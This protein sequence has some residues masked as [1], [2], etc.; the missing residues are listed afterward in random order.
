[1]TTKDTKV[2]LAVKTLAVGIQKAQKEMIEKLGSLV[3]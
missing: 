3:K 2:K 1:M